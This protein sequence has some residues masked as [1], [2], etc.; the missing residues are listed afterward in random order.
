MIC[1]LLHTCLPTAQRHCCCCRCCLLLPLLL[2]AAA[3]CCCRCCLLLLILY[4]CAAPATAA[5]A[6]A[7]AAAATLQLQSLLDKMLLG[8][9][10]LVVPQKKLEAIF[11]DEELT[12]LDFLKSRL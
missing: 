7:A 6:A 2:A 9:Y 11:T 4:R 10:R 12:T 3:A 5:A 8:L 1:M